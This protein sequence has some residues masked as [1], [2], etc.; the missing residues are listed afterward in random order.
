MDT[1]EEIRQAAWNDM[2]EKRKGNR[3]IA[4]SQNK[5]FGAKAIVEAPAVG[6]WYKFLCHCIGESKITYGKVTKVNSDGTIDCEK[7]FDMPEYRPYGGHKWF[8][9]LPWAAIID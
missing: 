4:L 6:R 2:I 8:D 3:N 1:D 5:V 9:D 7:C